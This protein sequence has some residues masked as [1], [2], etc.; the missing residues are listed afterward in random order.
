MQKLI[1][2]T[3]IFCTIFV[4]AAL[5]VICGAA[6]QKVIV[7]AGV[8]QDAAK[9]GREEASLDSKRTNG[10]VFGN[11]SDTDA[12]LCIPLKEGIKADMVSIENHYMNRELWVILEDDCGGFYDESLISGKQDK[13]EGGYYV[14]EGSRTKL[15]FSL[16]G[17]YEY[18]SILE[19]NSLLIEFLPPK[20][21]Y[22]KILV[23]DAAGGGGVSGAEAG[24]LKEKD[25]ALKIVK[26]LKVRL[27]A[28]D[29]KVYY[30]RMEDVYREESDRAAAANETKADMF[31][32]IQ[33]NAEEDAGRSGTT[34]VYNADYFIPGFGNVQLAD[35]LEREVVTSIKGRAAGL[36]PAKEDDYALK[37]AEVPAAAISVGYITN[38]KE[39][40]LLSEEGY[41]DKIA[42]GIYNTV[43]KAYE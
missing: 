23:I 38:E 8:A 12:Y 24:S 9:E 21:M 39:A 43:I 6:S 11:S 42:A 31:I 17:I 41:L 35:L 33:V 25:I 1:D 2:K 27:D 7:I 20:E 22:K 16:T 37:Q 29:I 36:V 34:A 4:I 14:Q 5:A 10:L 15:K 18:R 13:V 28:A 19:E 30:T 32:R 26:K 40:E 3:A